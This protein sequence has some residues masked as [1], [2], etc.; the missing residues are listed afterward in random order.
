LSIDSTNMNS[1]VQM[2]EILTRVNNED[3]LTYYEDAHFHYPDNHK[4]SYALGNW[5]IK[6]NEHRRTGKICREA[7]A[8]DSLNIRFQKLLGFAYYKMG[9]T[10]SSKK[11]LSKA[12]ALGDSSAFTFK[13][14]GI[15]HYL[16]FSI[17]EATHTLSMALEKDSM[18]AEVHFFL[19][20]ALASTKEKRRALEHLD[21]SIEIMKPEPKVMSRIYSEK[22]NIMRLVTAYEEA[23]QFYSMAWESDTTNIV[24]I[25]FMASI[26][27]N[28]LHRSKEALADYELYIEKLNLLPAV[29]Q[30][31]GQIPTIRNIVEDRIIT[32][33]E[34][35]FFLDE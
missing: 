34:E 29:A 4:V 3:A 24:S 1:L 5:Y 17:P 31:K 20:S 35:L 16:T 27:D 15:A 26:L 19:G 10:D 13:Y 23:Y 8:T 7:L 21:K 33:K 28:S 14:L 12:I 18:D 6:I 25:Y 11:H 30:S 22:G 32:L 9:V 2:G